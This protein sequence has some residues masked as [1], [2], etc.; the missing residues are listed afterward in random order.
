MEKK[1]IVTPDDGNPEEYFNVARQ[2]LEEDGIDPYT[3]FMK[4]VQAIITTLNNNN[5]GITE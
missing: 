3:T 5:N 1:Q 4:N 2:L